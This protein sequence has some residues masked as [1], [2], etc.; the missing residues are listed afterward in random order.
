MRIVF[1]A[2]LS[3]LALPAA[4]APLVFTYNAGA[5]LDVAYGDPFAPA[6][7]K[8]FVLGE[9]VLVTVTIDDAT[10]GVAGGPDSIDYFDAAGTIVLRGAT[11]GAEIST[12]PG[13]RLEVSSDDEFDVSSMQPLPGS[14]VNALDFYVSDDIDYRAPTGFLSDPTDIAAVVADIL[15]ITLPSGVLELPNLSQSSTGV[16]DYAD[17]IDGEAPGTPIPEADVE[18][19]F[20]ME[21][22]PVVSAP[23]PGGAALMLSGL[24]LL[25]LGRARRG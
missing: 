4:A 1:A 23:L 10:T 9:N 22:G 6:A 15:S 5:V 8:D 2:A 3:M 19:W 25:A 12:A 14:T 17:T 24:G 7:V 20:A 21:F 18:Y 13:V 11:S 16:V